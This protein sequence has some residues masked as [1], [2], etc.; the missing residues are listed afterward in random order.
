[1]S[2]DANQV[3]SGD[4]TPSDETTPV[5]GTAVAAQVTQ[6]LS[7]V[8]GMGALVYVTGGAIYYVRLLIYGV[9]GLTVTSSLPKEFLI[10][11]GAVGLVAPWFL[12]TCLYL[13]AGFWWN[14]G[15]HRWI[16]MLAVPVSLLAAF[17]W[18]AVRFDGKWSAALGVILALSLAIFVAIAATIVRVNEKLA[19]VTRSGTKVYVERPGLLFSRAALHGLALVP[20]GLVLAACLPLQTAEVCVNAA[21]SSASAS[22]VRE[23]EGR[24]LGQNRDRVWLAEVDRGSRIAAVPLSDATRVYLYEPEEEPR[25][26]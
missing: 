3:A 19:S 2:I 4:E 7:A 9:E 24:F 17:T 6:V 20:A 8:A 12:G 22:R 10:S 18:T 23:V 26:C 21:A 25:G 13:V 15:P 14:T 16:P 5:A 1:M 11:V